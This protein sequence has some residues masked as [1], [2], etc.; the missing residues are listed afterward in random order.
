MAMGQR[1]RQEQQPLFVSA[2][3][4]RQPPG[5]PYYQ[6][7][8]ALLASHGF[9]EWV[10]E[11]CRPFY[12]DTMG[13]PSL[14]PGIYFRCLMIGYLEGIDSERG[15]A[16]RAADSLSLRSLAAGTNVILDLPVRPGQGSG[17]PLG[18]RESTADSC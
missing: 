6:A 4:L 7:V 14:A 5:H 13:R 17:E 1:R 15:I 9:D 10:E 16:W 12:A 8:N 3:E 18:R 11:V 2:A